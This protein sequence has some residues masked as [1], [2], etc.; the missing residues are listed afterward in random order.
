MK[1][2]LIYLSILCVI[3]L[4]SCA[5]EFEKLLKSNDY[6][7]R[8]KEAYRYYDN[9]KYEQSAALFESVIAFYR[10]TPQDDSIQYYIA[11]CFYAQK[12]YVSAE[13]YYTT[14][15]QNFS[16]S[17]FTETADFRSGRCSYNMVPRT[18][19][20][21]TYAYKAIDAFNL[22]IYKYPNN[23]KTQECRDFLAELSAHLAKKSHK[24]AQLYY[25]IGEYRAAFITFKNC[26]K[27]FPDSKYRE[28]QLYYSLLSSFKLAEMS[29]L[30][31]K[32][33]RYQSAVD[34]YLNLISEYPSTKYLKES[35]RL[36]DKATAMLKKMENLD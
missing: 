8:Y 18:E 31:K 21:Q 7:R 33:E 27:D 9:K 17:I 24:S 16:R 20:D 4:S 11:E 13:H 35:K 26:L 30:D 28:E 19:L 22:Y 32:R 34:E 25:R 6:A 3:L 15:S 14:F 23:P 12:D 10:N 36:F 29:I 1:R 2:L 5:T